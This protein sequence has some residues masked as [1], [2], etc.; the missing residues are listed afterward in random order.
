M[1]HRDTALGDEPA[2]VALAHTEIAGGLRH[3]EQRI[4]EYVYAG[5]AASSLSH[6]RQGSPGVQAGEELPPSQPPGRIETVQ[7]ARYRYR[8]RVAPGQERALRA[9]FDACRFVWNQALSRW[10]ELWREEGLNYSYRDADRELTDWRGRFEWLA[11][12][13]SVPQQQALRDLYRSVT[14][15]FDKANP[16][17]RPKFKSRKSGYASAQWTLNGFALRDGRL[18]VAVAGGR[19]ALRVVWSRPLPSPP[20]SVRVYRDAVGRW[21][22]SFVVRTEHEDLGTTGET[23]GLDLGLRTFATTEFPDADVARPGF[24]RRAA[25]ALARSQRNL[26]RKQK[27]SANRAKAKVD[28]ANVH[29]KVTDQRRDWQH[30]EARRLARRF[31]RIGVEDLR[32]K[33][34][35]A[36]R[37]LARAI[38]D[39]SWGD[40]LLALEHHARK[41]GH[42][43]VRL[44]PRNTSQT[45]SGCG[46][47][48]KHRLGLADRVF[49]CD[50]CGLVEDRDRNAARNLNPNRL[51]CTGAGDDGSKTKVPAGTLAA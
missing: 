7:E 14:A 49:A 43:V 23:T 1:L 4:H 34:M 20:K 29:A 21:W 2:H 11:A 19:A 39:A 36:N 42:E 31:D 50:E 47:K 48:A 22:A 8:L 16:A 30:K 17:G 40:F 32:V 3:T 41:C 25:K 18:C 24:A 38:A 5:T 12:Q 26:A 9:V 46:A 15:F 28:V 13:P 44:N 6:P 10:G 45:C 51:G 27:G 35:M 37:H 33:N